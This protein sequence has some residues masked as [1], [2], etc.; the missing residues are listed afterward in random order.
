MA[1]RDVPAE[2]LT[3]V[4]VETLRH[5]VKEAM[6]QNTPRVLSSDLAYPEAWSMAATGSPSPHPKPCC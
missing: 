2:V 4:D 5:L 1:H 6:D 3:D